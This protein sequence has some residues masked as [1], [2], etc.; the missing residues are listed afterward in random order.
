M[1]DASF[2]SIRPS[3]SGVV[4]QVDNVLRRRRD[5]SFF[6]LRINFSLTVPNSVPSQREKDERRMRRLAFPRARVGQAYSVGGLM[7]QATCA[8]TQSDAPQ[9]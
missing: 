1:F 7:D 5:E 2:L 4:Q 8:F 9:N 3:P 6:D